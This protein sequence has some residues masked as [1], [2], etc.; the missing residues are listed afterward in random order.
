[1]GRLILALC[2]ALAYIGPAALSA[3][4][5]KDGGEQSLKY[6]IRADLTLA[7]RLNE[8]LQRVALPTAS[9]VEKSVST[10]EF[11]STRCGSA[12]PPQ[13]LGSAVREYGTERDDIRF[14]PCIRIERLAPV[15][16]ASGE[17]LESL[18]TRLGFANWGNAHF[19]VYRGS[20]PYLKRVQ[21]PHR[22]QEG[23]VV[24]APE[25]PAWTTIELDRSKIEDGTSL[26]RELAKAVDC[27]ERGDPELCLYHRGVLVFHVNDGSHAVSTQPVGRAARS[28][29]LPDTRNQAAR[30]WCSASPV[31]GW[32]VSTR[33]AE[34]ARVCPRG[35][36][37]S[38]SLASGSNV[39]AAF[40]NPIVNPAPTALAVV[41]EA[42]PTVAAGQW[43]YD[44]QLTSAALSAAY[45]GRTGNPAAVIGIADYGLATGVGAPLPANIFSMAKPYST[46]YANDLIG[47]GV[48]RPPNAANG[49][50]RLCP[51]DLLSSQK[52]NWNAEDFKRAS[53]GAVVASI[54]AGLPLREQGNPSLEKVLPKIVF[55]RLMGDGCTNGPHLDGI[56]EQGVFDAVEYLSSRSTIVNVSYVDDQKNKMFGYALHDQ[57]KVGGG[58]LVVPA[59][60][61]TVNLD[62]DYMLCPPCLANARW[63]LYERAVGDR[64]LVIGA[65]TQNL[66]RAS[67]SGRGKLTVQLYAPGEPIGGI[68]LFGNDASTYDPAT[69]YAAPYASLAIGVLY[70]LGSHDYAEIVHRL[71]AASWPLEEAGGDAITFDANVI[72]MVKVAAAS[73]YS[74]EV[75]EAD[76]VSKSKVRHT[77]V[78]NI[79]RRLEDLALC[80]GY[81]ID[82]RVYQA[83]R[84]GAPDADGNRLISMHTRLARDPDPPRRLCHPD[85]KIILTDLNGFQRRFDLADIS[86]ILT[87]WL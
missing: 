54:A 15:E 10:R 45:T 59:T 77:Y 17:T 48:Q 13:T 82:E 20:L 61:R 28:S 40:V 62:D 5:P 52:L 74:I 21:Q 36:V 87:P 18:A 38:R 73:S 22:L 51:D 64:V 81:P 70:A 44:R 19:R 47:A 27:S 3:E 25:V 84:I 53:H 30:F 8:V 31:V 75:I 63:P 24:V 4:P 26:V 85:G 58:L 86:E 1:M 55:F 71:K 76:S 79:G 83:V 32:A 41:A 42:E 29:S 35:P 78:G 23:D 66:H 46:R 68:D 37:L 67:Y 69:S 43:P 11:L 33:A 56:Q 60:D 57:V 16:V 14:A 12:L 72:D 34:L 65:A 80:A 9:S 7:R 2:G 39:L 50:V 49:D 6:A